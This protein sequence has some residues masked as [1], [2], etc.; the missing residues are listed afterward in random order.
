MEVTRNFVD[1]VLHLAIDGRIDSY[2]ADHLDA[3]LREVIGEG[4]HRLAIDCEKVSFLSSAGIGV[5]VRHYK[6]LAAIKGRFRIVRASSAVVSTLNISR[7][8]ELLIGDVEGIG[9]LTTSFLPA[10][11]AEAEGV[12]L[13]VFDLRP[14]GSLT[15]GALGTPAPLATGG[16]T[17]SQ[18]VSLEGTT[19]AFAIGLGAFG[20]G[21]DVC[22]SR[23]GELISV[24]G[25]TAYLPADGTNVP[26]Y[27]VARGPLTSG[28]H[29]LYGLA[30]TGGFAQLLRFEPA[31][32]GAVT[33]SQLAAACLQIAGTDRI[34]MV[35]AAETA[36]LVGAALRR[37]PVEPIAGGVL[38]AYPSIRSRLTFTAERAFVHSLTLTAG[39]VSHG[40][41]GRP[42]DALLRPYGERL[43][44]H[45]HAAAFRFKPL[46]KGS[47]DLADTVARLFDTDQLLGVMHLLH[48]DRSGSGAGES[49]L[50]RGAC[51]IAPVS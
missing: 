12:A 26:D 35:V 15:C 28:I 1:G 45:L 30:C 39:I 3:A 44:A 13:E 29:V 36:G 40:N 22:R 49:E 20:D 46:Q 32:G 11:S 16:F 7:L 9:A 38:F 42:E 48:D 33:I 5:F 18:C 8:S 14:P 6:Q 10:R 34:G 19:P 4:H 31:S 21:F 51:W 37:S 47:I 25:A 23:F 24:A 43:T 41:A 27:L 17:E 50:V 2:W